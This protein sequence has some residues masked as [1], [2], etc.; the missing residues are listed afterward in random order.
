MSVIR[1]PRTSP[2]GR[3]GGYTL[4]E[5]LVAA[6]ILTGGLIGLASM[7]A[8][9]TR[10]NNSAYLRT[11]ASILAYDI[12]DRMRANRAAVV[13]NSYDIALADATPGSPTTV[14][15]IDLV[16]W[17]TALA[18]YLPAGNGS[19]ETDAGATADAPQR[20]TITVQWNDGRATADV[21]DFALTTDL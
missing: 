1:R 3:Q 13:A 16:Q 7:Q 14:A 18:Y 8:S 20:A 17:R 9:G 2:H 12:A 6:I 4:L 15:D 11:Q 21:I 19:I 10:L 5:I